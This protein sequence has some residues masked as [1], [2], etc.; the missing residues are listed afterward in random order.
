MEK[1]ELINVSKK[2]EL[3]VIIWQEYNIGLQNLLEKDKYLRE[4]YNISR[5]IHD[6]TNIVKQ[7]WIRAVKAARIAV[8]NDE[9]DQDPQH[10][11]QSIIWRAVL[12]TLLRA[13]KYKSPQ[14]GPVQQPD[15]CVDRD[16]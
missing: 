7:R 1:V 5:L 2:R 12:R 9:N 11:Q 16:R 14:T 4:N 13:R 10:A 8:E 3:D 15:K 6:S